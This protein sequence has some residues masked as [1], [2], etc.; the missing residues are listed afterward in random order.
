MG[1]TR[2]RRRAA[3]CRK[4]RSSASATVAV[5]CIRECL[6]GSLH[7]SVEFCVAHG[8]Q[9]QHTRWRRRRRIGHTRPD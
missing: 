2:K 3:Q 5:G 4:S 8:A 7:R 6:Y 1:R 9:G